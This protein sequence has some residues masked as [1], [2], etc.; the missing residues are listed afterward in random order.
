MISVERSLYEKFPRL[1]EGVARSFSQ[2]VVDL[3]RKITCEERINATLSALANH[4]GFEFVE[5]ALDLLDVSYSVANTDRENIPVDGGVVIVSNHPLGA[6]D[7]LCL[8]HLV[9][10]VRRDVR[11]LANDV[12]MQLSPLNTLL[13]PINVFGGDGAG[14]GGMREAYRALEAGQALIVFPS[15]EVSRVRPNGVRDGRWSSGFVRMARKTGVP[16]LP[17]HINAHNS[18]MFYGISLLAKPLSALL[19][20]REM[21][22]MRGERIGINVGQLVPVSELERDNETPDYVAKGMRR[23]VYQLAKRRPN[24]FTTSTAIA[25]PESPLAV[26][27]ALRDR[28]EILGQT[29]DGKRILLIDSQPDCPVMREVG[30]LREVV[31]RKVGEGTGNRRDLDAFD[32]YYRHLVLWDEESLAIV[33]AYRLGEA[34]T[35]VANRGIPGLYSATLFDYAPQAQEFL[36][37]AVEL[38]RSFIQPAYWGSRSLDY[39]WQ[40]IGAYL[41]KRP[42]VRYLFGPVSLSATLPQAVRE[43]IVHTHGRFFQD[44]E[45]LARARN[46]FQVSP[47]VAREADAALDGLDAKGALSLLKQQLAT[48]DSAIPT[49]YRQYV[50]LCE[51]DGV[52][53]LAFGVDPQF[54]GCV[55]GL[56]RLDLTRLKPAKRARYLSDPDASSQ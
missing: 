14:S 39:L 50:D 22:G 55:D 52:R 56:I 32:T 4:T 5:Q 35:I 34:G 54:G 45:Q 44:P 33:G 2:P 18:A 23:H 1:A 53:F 24:V 41:R 19:L 15:G 31:F 12:L 28:A 51:P 26:R 40:G 29:T 13:L 49:L 46:P 42:Q 11:I 25:H 7:A 6:V 16:V 17:V 3:L 8:L 38:G 21:F 47:A 9:G 27:R 30:R 20:A 36:K 10:S 43:L 48:A 37:D